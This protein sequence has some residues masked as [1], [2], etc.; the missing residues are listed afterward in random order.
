MTLRVPDV[1]ANAAAACGAD[2]WLADLPR[3]VADLE[4]E[5]SVSVA[6]PYPYAT[7]AFV[8]EAS[9]SDG[10]PAVLKLLIPHEGTVVGHEIT[11]L[12][13]AGGQG[14]VSL[15]RHDAAR[16]ALLLERL[17]PSLFELGRPLTQ[18]LEILVT[19]ATTLWRPAA[20]AG[21][22]TG[23]DKAGRL[24]DFVTT[25][26]EELGHPC[27][28]AAVD[29]AVA[30]AARRVAAHDDERAVLV[31][32]DVH[33]LNALQVP[34]HTSFKLVDPEG[35]LAEAECDLGVMMRND[36]M[37][38]LEGDPWGRAR[39]LAE[40]CGLDATAIWEWGVVERVASGLRCTRIDLQ[41]L[42]RQML[43]VADRLATL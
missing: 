26:W 29:Q 1:V 9:L 2:R 35:L 19:T 5:W 33:Q 37:E 13:L 12:Q 20:G 40:R 22:P 11:M 7:E 36:P 16:G 42:G 41:P 3:L 31:H 21:L 4:A 32:G 25:Q 43:M 23:A 10:T 38:L 24:V 30:C 6:R 8:A 15:L 39:W 14:C 34:G 27:S 17:G 18:R 28:E